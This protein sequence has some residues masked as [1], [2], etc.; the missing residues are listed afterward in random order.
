MITA[1][2]RPRRT[3]W[4]RNGLGLVSTTDRLT[5]VTIAKN[6]N[7]NTNGAGR[8]Q[9]IDSTE[10]GADQD[11]HKTGDQIRPSPDAKEV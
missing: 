8:L 9:N 10:T 7:N 11:V 1:P 5:A 2:L 4:S 6:I 3:A